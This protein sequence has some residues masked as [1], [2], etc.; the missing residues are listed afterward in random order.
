[1]AKLTIQDQHADRPDD[2][3]DP[4]DG[5]YAV[6]LIGA[7]ATHRQVLRKEGIVFLLVV[8][9]GHTVPRT[10]NSGT[11]ARREAEGENK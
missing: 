11:N 1:M 2:H 3:K 9:V 6:V 8:G 10:K 4:R 5:K 7:V